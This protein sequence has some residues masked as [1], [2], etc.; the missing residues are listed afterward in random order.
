MRAAWPSLPPLVL[1][2]GEDVLLIEN[3]KLLVVELEFGACVLLEEDAVPLLKLNGDALSGVG[4]PVAGSDGE[5]FPLL[6]LLLRGVRQNDPALGD[7]L[8][9]EG[10][11]H[12]AGAERLEPEF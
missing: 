3:E 2:L 12:D 11:D 4:M 10:L 6:G 9:L 1:D 8:A 7:L 5:N